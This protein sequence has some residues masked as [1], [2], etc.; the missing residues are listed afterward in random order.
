MSFT[1]WLRRLRSAQSPRQKRRGSPRLL[2]VT[3]QR[4]TLEALED[5]CLLSFAAPVNYV[6]G[7]GSEALVAGDFNGD[8]VLDLAVANFDSTVSVLLGNGDGTFQQPALASPTGAYPNSIAVGDFNADG[9]LDVATADGADVS[10]LLGNGDGT[11]QPPSSIDLGSSPVSVAVG[12]F[13]GDGK[14]D[15]GV[16]SNGIVQQCCDYYG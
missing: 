8:H 4:P 9:K 11:F 6:V 7:S 3:T 13:N 12:D 10:V 15:L 5:R 1:T 16:T 2:P 14:L